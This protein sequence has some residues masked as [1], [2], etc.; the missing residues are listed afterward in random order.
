MPNLLYLDAGR[1][2]A[3]ITGRDPR[4]GQ[5]ADDFEVLLE[6]APSAWHEVQAWSTIR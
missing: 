1:R 5:Y 3:L 2:D 6:S 4:I